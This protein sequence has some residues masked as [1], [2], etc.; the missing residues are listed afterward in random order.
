MGNQRN[1]ISLPQ[2]G[3]MVEISGDL[4]CL[5]TAEIDSSG[6]THT[7]EIPKREVEQGSV[8]PNK[9]TRVA[10][11]ST[12][13]SNLQ[14]ESSSNSQASTRSTHSEGPPVDNGDLVDIEIDSLGDKGDGIGRVGPGY[15]VIVPDTDVG[16]RV[17]VRITEAKEN[18]AFAEVVKRYDPQ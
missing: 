3:G 9:P 16:E 7:L 17:N 13:E 12:A 8:R 11:F 10:I 15:V 4:L 14:P 2:L 18:V 1:H 5:Y 6:D